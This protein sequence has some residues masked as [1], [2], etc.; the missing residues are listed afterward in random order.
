M[1]FPYVSTSDDEK[2]ENSLLSGFAEN[3]NNGFEKDRISYTDTC[4]VTGQDLKKHHSMDS[5]RVS[6]CIFLGSSMLYLFFAFT[7]MYITGLGDIM[8][9]KQTKWTDQSDC[10]L[11]WWFRG[12]RPCKIRRLE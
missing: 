5:V 4:T 2:L 1:A 12:F 6:Y 10:L 11:Q 3:C 8:D 7:N 9:G